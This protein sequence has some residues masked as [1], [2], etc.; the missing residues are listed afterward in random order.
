M[1]SLLRFATQYQVEYLQ[2]QLVSH[3]ALRY[4]YTLFNFPRRTERNHLVSVQGADLILLAQETQALVLLPVAL[5]EFAIVP[6]SEWDKAFPDIHLLSTNQLR[7][8]VRGR[9]R[10]QKALFEYLG[11]LLELAPSRYPD[12]DDPQVPRY[13]SESCELIDCSRVGIFFHSSPLFQTWVHA[14]DLL[15][16]T[17]H[18]DWIDKMEYLCDKCKQ[19]FRSRMDDVR[20]C[21]W[22]E[23]PGYFDLLTWA[24]LKEATGCRGKDDDALEAERRHAAS[25]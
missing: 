9:E 11:Q 23:L 3:L 18:T 24:D 4:P 6:P 12:P 2:Q 15:T 19:C 20:R 25:H 13:R 22:K 1:K 7:T 10:L 8:I 16:F 5:Y 21:V 14:P 17:K